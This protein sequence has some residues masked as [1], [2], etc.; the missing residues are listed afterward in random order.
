MSLMPILIPLRVR[1]VLIQLALVLARRERVLLGQQL[2][3]RSV[4]QW[5]Q[6]SAQL[7]AL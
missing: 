5:V 2:V 7:L 4:G 6:L 1:Q 3:A